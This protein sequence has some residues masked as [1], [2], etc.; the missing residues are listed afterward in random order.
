MGALA[1]GEDM[2]AS[3]VVENPSILET[4][5]PPAAD[6][7][8]AIRVNDLHKSFRIPTHRVDSLKERMVRPFS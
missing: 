6:L 7:P 1:F 3:K 2:S 4:P 5:P 8:P